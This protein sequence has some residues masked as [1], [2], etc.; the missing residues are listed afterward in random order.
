MTKSNVLKTFKRSCTKNFVLRER[1]STD[2]I[3][4]YESSSDS[5]KSEKNMKLKQLD[6]KNNIL[7]SND[8]QKKQVIQFRETGLNKEN[9]LNEKFDKSENSVSSVSNDSDESFDVKK[10]NQVKRNV[11][12]QT[13]FGPRAFLPYLPAKDSQ[14]TKQLDLKK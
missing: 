2:L 1:T 6:F 11:R 4:R 14:S 3:E 7:G 13:S 10:P 9:T 5:M 12:M 8:E